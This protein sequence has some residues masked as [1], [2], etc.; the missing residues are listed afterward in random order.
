MCEEGAQAKAGEEEM[1]CR[2]GGTTL[3]AGMYAHKATCQMKG[4]GKPGRKFI[5][6]VF[7]GWAGFKEGS[8]SELPRAS[9]SAETSSDTKSSTTPFPLHRHYQS[10]R[11]K[12]YLFIIPHGFKTRPKSS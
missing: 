10:L 12:D 1:R 6:K 2:E 4:W 7:D 11:H 3:C 9:T 5:V 8:H